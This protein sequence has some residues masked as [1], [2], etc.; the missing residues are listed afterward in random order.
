[1]GLRT[2]QLIATETNVTKVADPLGGSYYV[3]SLTDELEKRIWD[4]I[5]DIEAKGDPAEL[6]DKGFFKKFFDDI[7][8]RYGKEI[9]E[10][11]LPKVGLNCFQIPEEQ[12]TL[13]KDVSETKIEPYRDRIEKIKDYK[14]SR[15]QNQVKDALRNCLEK[16]KT[17]G[18]NLTY[19]TIDALA[20]GA[21]FGEISGV[22]RTAYD[23]PYDPHGKVESII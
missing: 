21:T 23:Y 3:E 15:D 11:E 22:L 19:P 4:M 13:L 8:V 16:A 1:V 12:D 10:G 5:V 6:S 9:E 7:M 20:A 17:E 18:E 2:Q 14:Q